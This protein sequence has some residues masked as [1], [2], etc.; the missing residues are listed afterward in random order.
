[1]ADP[2]DVRSDRVRFA[3]DDSRR[4]RYPAQTDLGIPVVQSRY[5]FATAFL[6]PEMGLSR[7]EQLSIDDLVTC[8]GLIRQRLEVRDRPASGA[9]LG[10]ASYSLPHSLHSS[11]MRGPLCP[12]YSWPSDSEGEDWVTGHQA[13]EQQPGSS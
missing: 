10:H 11:A 3:K 12:Q 4:S 1:M 5:A 8:A 13:E 6:M 9:G 2:D 7:H